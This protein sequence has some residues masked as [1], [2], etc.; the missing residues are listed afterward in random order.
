MSLTFWGFIFYRRPQVILS[1]R[2]Y[3]IYVSLTFRRSVLELLD[4]LESHTNVHPLV[5]ASDVVIARRRFDELTRFVRDRNVFIVLD[6]RDD[7][8]TYVELSRRYE[9]VKLVPLAVNASSLEELSKTRQ[10]SIAFLVDDISIEHVK[11]RF[12]DAQILYPVVQIV[13]FKRTRRLSEV[14][15]TSLAKTLLAPLLDV[16]FRR[17]CNVIL[18][19]SCVV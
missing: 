15:R 14:R 5:L 11:R 4:L 19:M 16:C 13:G 6:S 2:N 9:N 10:D 17:R 3:L 1:F 18:D 12:N 8:R 7:V